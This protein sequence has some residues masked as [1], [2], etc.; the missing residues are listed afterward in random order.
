M[1]KILRFLLGFICSLICLAAILV[2][3]WVFYYTHHTN[4]KKIKTYATTN[5]EITGSTAIIAH[6][7]GAGIVPEELLAAFKY[8][9]ENEDMGVE[10]LE[11]DLHIT[12]DD[13]IILLHDDSLDRT[14]DAVEVFG[15]SNNK[16]REYTL[17]ELK[18]LNMGA[19]FVDKNGN[20][21]YVDLN[22]VENPKDY[23]IATL[24]EAFDY[25]LSKGDFTYVI[26]IKNSA[27][28]GGLIIADKL[29]DELKARGLLQK[30]YVNSFNG[31][32]MQYIATNYPDVKMGASTVDVIDFVLAAYTN[33]K[34]FN[35]SYVGLHLPYGDLSECYGVNT[36]A[37]R[38]INYAHEHDISVA[39]WTI[40]DPDQMRYLIS[41]G[42]DG[43]M[44]DYPDVL[45]E[46]MD[47]MRANGEIK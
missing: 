37:A 47:E 2:I 28:D 40:N 3:C 16:A 7:A 15:R 18:I 32:I 5:T 43:I 39:Y 4:P 25:L 17:E 33:K 1:K 30:A 31:E 20:M 21:P 13:E 29:Y 24:K 23:R 9:V 46:V 22:Q 19:K 44:T 26:E 41:I 42:A 14:S 27:S 8:C 36:S 34:D 45:K 35:P 38:I 10:W 11:F 12:A 6:R